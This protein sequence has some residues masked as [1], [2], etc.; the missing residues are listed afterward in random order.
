MGPNTENICAA[1][2]HKFD[3]DRKSDAGF[4]QLHCGGLGHGMLTFG[5]VIGYIARKPLK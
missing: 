2:L 1:S 4:G 3:A 5:Q